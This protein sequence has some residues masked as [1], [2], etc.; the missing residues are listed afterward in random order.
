MRGAPHFSDSSSDKYLLMPGP[1]G[2]QPLPRGLGFGDS[3][4]VL[5][6]VTLWGVQCW[7]TSLGSWGP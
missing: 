6:P 3:S 1:E 5:E 2:A 4:P 7:H